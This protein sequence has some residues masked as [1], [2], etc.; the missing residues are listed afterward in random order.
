MLRAI[1]SKYP[2]Q[3]TPY[4]TY[5]Q[6]ESDHHDA[7]KEE[8]E[9]DEDGIADTCD[10]M[11]QDL[12][13]GEIDPNDSDKLSTEQLG[14]EMVVDMPIQPTP[15]N[16]DMPSLAMGNSGYNPIEIGE[17]GITFESSDTIDLNKYV[18]LFQTSNG[19][20]LI[21]IESMADSSEHSENIQMAEV[22]KLL[23]FQIEDDNSMIDENLIGARDGVE[24]ISK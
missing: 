21:G 7:V 11:E 17:A 2:K 8:D 15:N 18:H 1:V 22:G 6:C 24:M 14:L 4:S 16:N 12:K 20:S 13:D 3:P 19:F 23:G 5:R 10:Q 9:E